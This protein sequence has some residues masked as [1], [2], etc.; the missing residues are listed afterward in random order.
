MNRYEKLKEKQ[1]TTIMQEQDVSR[2]EAEEIRRQQFRELGA[3]GGAVGGTPFKYSR[4][5][6]R[7]A[8]ALSAKERRLI[9]VSGKH[10]TI[11]EVANAYGLPRSLVSARLYTG[12]SWEDIVAPIRKPEQGYCLRGHEMDENNAY[13]SP[14]GAKQCRACRKIRDS[15]GK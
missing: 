14:K 15:R 1:I 13:V 4:E 7:E 8:Q 10:M 11:S 2:E 9:N 5:L 3:R 12:K 6:A